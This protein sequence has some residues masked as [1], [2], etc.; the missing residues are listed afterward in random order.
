MSVKP[1]ASPIYRPAHRIERENE[2]AG[3]RVTRAAAD[4]T[5]IMSV[6]TSIERGRVAY[7]ALDL[8]HKGQAS[9]VHI[10]EI[11]DNLRQLGWSV[12][13]FTPRP[14]TPEQPRNVVAKAYEY[15][16]TS[17]QAAMSLR[18]HDVLYVRAHALTW[19]VAIVARLSGR[20]LVE[21]VNGTELDLI[22]SR[23]WLRP[24]RG[25]LRWLYVSQYRRSHHLFPVAN[26]LADWLR[27]ETRHDRISVVPN[28][29]NTDLFR[30]IEREPQEPFVVFF[31]GLTDW[32]GVDVMV[33]AI[34]HPAWPGGIRLVV[35][36]TGVRQNLVADAV[37]AGL[38]IRWLG[39]QPY[40]QIPGLIA[41]AI[42]G[43]IP[44]TNPLGRSSTGMN[45][46]KLFETLA[47]G[48]PA[49]VSELPGQADLV[50]G[51]RCGLVV[52]C[53]DAAALARAVGELAADPVA[54]R[55]MG[56]RGA[57]MVRAAHSWR[58]RAV[59]IDKVLRACLVGMPR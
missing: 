14:G 6:S 36:G 13:L 51:G 59:E 27:A 10:H 11:V 12:D 38:P 15:L 40:E 20:V 46:L 39:Y 7:F 2:F 26:E 4:E 18:T 5:L 24:L 57:A 48:I 1:F 49:I 31:G 43:L 55:E 45:P 21:E 8:P 53:G 30:P 41:G 23:P 9:Y 19:P 33:D 44:M 35:I 3:R 17:W 37:R 47:C 32:H 52:P 34:R 50:R 25:L 42:A 58:A 56:R 54:A 29:A 22:V 28:A 16:R